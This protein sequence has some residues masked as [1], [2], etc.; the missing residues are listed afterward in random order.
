MDRERTRP[1]VLNTAAAGGPQP[2]R[3]KSTAT[4]LTDGDAGAGAGGTFVLLSV[5]YCSAPLLQLLFFPR[6]WQNETRL[7]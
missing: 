3:R 4:K 5:H 2:R 1:Q 6:S 7:L